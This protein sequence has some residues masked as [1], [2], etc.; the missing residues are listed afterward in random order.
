MIEL[1]INN[2]RPIKNVFAEFSA[3]EGD[4]SDEEAKATLA[5][6]LYH[7]PAFLMD[8]L[9]GIKLF[10]FQEIIIKGWARNDYNLGVWGRGLSKSY[11][12][13][14]FAL[15]WAIF[16]PNARIVIASYS[17]RQSRAILELCAKLIK[18]ESAGLLRACFPDDLR[19]KTDEYIL[20]VPNGAVIRCLP[21]GDG[22]SIRGV[23]AD[24]LIVDEFAFL[25]ENIIAEILRPFLASKNKITEQ[26]QV[27]ERESEMIAQGL[28]S[29]K[30][31]TIVDDRKKV[32]FLSS[33]SYQFEHLYRQYKSWT[34]ILMLDPVRDKVKY[35]EF[36]AAGRG[37]FV[38]RLSWEAAPAGL[39]DMEEIM[40]AKRETSESMFNREYGAQFTNDSDGFYRASKMQECTIPDGEA[41]CL[42]LTGE[43]KAEY[44]LGI[45][46]SLSGSE[47]SDHF[48]MCLM[49]VVTRATDGKKIGMV[50][51]SYA[52]A[53]GNLK[54]HMLYL[55]YLMKNFNIVYIGVDASGGD[56]L[57]FIN[58]CNQS[59]LFQDS[60][61]KLLDIGADFKKHTFNEVVTEIRRGYNKTA[62]KIVQKQPFSSEWQ[63]SSNEYLQS[64]FDHK[65]ILFG[66]KIAA[67]GSSVSRAM[68]LDLSIL[69]G[70]ED[71]KETTASEFI[72]NQDFL[73]DLT[74]K[75]CALIQVKISTLGTMGFE[76]PQ[77][78]RRTTGPTR[79]RKDSYSALLIA[80][81][82][83]KMYTEA[84]AM[85][86][87]TGPVEFPY[88]FV[89]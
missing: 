76:L 28:M 5:E 48:A 55:F 69:S 31:R 56:E 84:M 61:I 70:H 68:S 73:V 71:F 60:D 52:V 38:S 8:I 43:E 86:I 39:L 32:I 27:D 47:S 18:Q 75:E 63:R 44:V 21:L 81:W 26:R 62:G 37:Y 45:D 7:N 53:G 79:V 64:C 51:H 6:F 4:L 89:G 2:V 25:P 57:E 46:Q 13:S 1:G 14:T 85:E 82:C 87:K 34:D 74:K 72:S 83:V 3:L 22:R 77:N 23:R 58:S 36:K 12:V 17:F 40:A 54:D 42:E 15:Y 88:A 10:P 80:N 11:S 24:V 9:G 19:T 41:P 29:E 49:K 66:G 16:N 20:Q 65:N 50:V 33:A 67:H 78:L 35:D 59:K 30:D